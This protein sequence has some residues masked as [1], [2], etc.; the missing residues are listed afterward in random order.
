MWC[1]RCQKNVETW[2]D[3]YV[4]NGVKFVTIMCKEC[5]GVL[6]EVRYPVMPLFASSSYRKEQ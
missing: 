4:E 3:H 1:P 6:R 5:N 2:Q